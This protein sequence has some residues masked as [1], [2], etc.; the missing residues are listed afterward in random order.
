MTCSY[1]CV[2][3]ATCEG[4]ESCWNVQFFL[5]CNLSAYGNKCVANMSCLWNSVLILTTLSMNFRGNFQLFDIAP[6]IITELLFW[7]RL[8]VRRFSDVFS[9]VVEHTISFLALKDCSVQN[10]FSSESIILSMFF[11]LCHLINFSCLCII[12]ILCDLVKPWTFLLR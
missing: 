2:D 9:K 3:F 7:K 12:F 5:G 8:T 10:I 11:L 1:F 6:K 4:V